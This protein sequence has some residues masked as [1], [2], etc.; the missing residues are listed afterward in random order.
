M[1]GAGIEAEKP[2]SI[3]AQDAPRIGDD[4]P[5][6]RALVRLAVD[7]DELVR[8]PLDEAAARGLPSAERRD[9]RGLH[10]RIDRV[11]RRGVHGA[12]LDDAGARDVPRLGPGRG[13]AALTKARVALLG[14]S[15]R[16][17]P[18][19][20]SGARRVVVG[21]RRRRLRAYLDLTADGHS[22]HAQ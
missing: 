15:G 21:A 14:R 17:G 13:G 1:N 16:G 3:E 12:E 11:D 4:Q 7:R 22:E 19:G 20:R 2:R 10:L 18:H 8:R 6:L 5:E 9:E